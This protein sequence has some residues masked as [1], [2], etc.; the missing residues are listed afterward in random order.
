MN[1]GIDIDGVLNNLDEYY[2]VKGIQYCYQHRIPYV[3]HIDK[4]KLREKYDWDKTT[5]R[6]FYQ[7]NYVRFLM[8]TVYLRPYAV[9]V[10]L[11]LHKKHHIIII[12]SR[13]SHDIPA[14]INETVEGLTKRWLDE[15]GIVYDKLIFTKSNKTNIILREKITIMIEDNPE[16]L[17]QVSNVPIDFLCFDTNYNR[18]TFPNNVYRIYSWHEILSFIER[19]ESTL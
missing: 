8:S 3:M 2:I 16:Y 13:Q 18:K 12:T 10:I 15:N 5:E 11:S 19:K 9:E 4:Y 1:I 14:Y 17:S 7:E 6:A